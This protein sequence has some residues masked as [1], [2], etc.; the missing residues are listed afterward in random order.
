ME[1]EMH[2]RH[3]YIRSCDPNGLTKHH[4]H[5]KSHK[6]SYSGDINEERNI[7]NVKRRLHDSWHNLFQDKS[8]QEI[9]RIITQVWISPDYEMI[10]RRRS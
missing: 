4:R 10:V 7:V 5:P 8:P 2:K 1:E 6:D 3:K 9:A